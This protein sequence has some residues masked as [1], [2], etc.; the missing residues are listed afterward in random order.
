[1]SFAARLILPCVVALVAT[2]A[3]AQALRP[4]HPLTGTWRITAPGGCSET[5]VVRPNGTATITSGEEIAESELTISDQPSG[6]GFFKWAEKIVKDNGKKD[7]SGEVS[8]VGHVVV[9]YIQLSPTKDEFAMCEREDRNSC[10][11]P[12]KRVK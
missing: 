9:S 6:R 11:G 10:I 8:E 12:F 2:A 1:M 4:D 7:C 5:Y 3:N